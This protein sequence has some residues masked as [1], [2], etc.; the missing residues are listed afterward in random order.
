MYNFNDL[1]SLVTS[2]D[3]YKISHWLQYPEDAEA[4]LFYIESRGGKFDEVVTAG[5]NYISSLL[6]KPI[7]IEQV[8]FANKLYRSHFGKDIFNYNGWMEIAKLGFIPVTFRAIPEG[9]PVPVKHAVATVYADKEFFWLAGHLETLIVRGIWYPSTVA[10]LSRECKKVLKH[11]MDITSDLE[12]VDY[13]ITLRTR[14]HDFGARG[15][16]SAES[17]GI[18]GLAHLYNFIGTDTVEAMIMAISL[19][20]DYG[21]IGNE[22][23]AAGVSIPAREHSTTI[24]YGQ[25]DEDAA[26]KNSIE[27]FGDGIYACVYDS[28]DYKAAVDRIANYRDQILQAGGTLV[29]RPDSGDM[30]DNIMYTLETAGQIFG[31]TVNSKGYKVLHSAVRII[32][33]DEIHGPDTINRVLNWMESNKW[34]SENIAFGM[35]GGL[36]QEVTRDTQKYAMKLCAIMIDG[37]WRST[38]KCPKGSEWKKSKKGYVCT[39]T[40]GTEWA[41][42]DLLTEEIPFGWWDAMETYYLDGWVKTD[43]TLE[44]VRNRARV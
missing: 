34:A 41:S 36:L 12:G 21:V 14:L 2:V 40:N 9:T 19:Y 37:Q 10:T 7:T 13:D 27:M 15:A 20:R 39:I 42:I 43:D 26:Y 33:G 44:V 3:S 11:Y 35:G 23:K 6:K 24:S 29:I 5:V 8:E 4:A 32:Q 1:N 31:Y 30:V 17:A 18:G 22:V 16:S 28:W 38:Y 25:Y